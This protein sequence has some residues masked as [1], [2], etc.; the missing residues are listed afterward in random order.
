MEP[1]RIIS[2]TCVRDFVRAFEWLLV[3]MDFF[4]CRKLYEESIL[5]NLFGFRKMT[6]EYLLRQMWVTDLYF[7]K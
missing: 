6:E 4:I 3:R 5:R 2:V 1:P 7:K